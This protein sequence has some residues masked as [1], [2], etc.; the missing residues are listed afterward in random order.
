[1][2]CDFGGHGVGEAQLIGRRN[3]IGKK[4]GFLPPR[5]S[6]DDFRKTLSW[7]I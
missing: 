3:S 6:V 1:M 5:D 4:P 7:T 2:D